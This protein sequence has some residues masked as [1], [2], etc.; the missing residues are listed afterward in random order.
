MSWYNLVFLVYLEGFEPGSPV[1]STYL[2]DFTK[3]Q[4]R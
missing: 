1:D 3:R 4:K 2:T